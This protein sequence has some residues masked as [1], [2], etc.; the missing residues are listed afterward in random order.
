MKNGKLSRGTKLRCIKDH[1]NAVVSFKKGNTYAVTT[2]FG[3]LMD[4]S[5]QF[6]VLS[7]TVLDECFRFFSNK[8]GRNEKMG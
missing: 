2:D 8:R 6:V 1:I 3:H 4:D 5:F 7:D